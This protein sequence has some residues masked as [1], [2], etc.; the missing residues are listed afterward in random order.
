MRIPVAWLREYCDPGLGVDDLATAL[1]LSGTE[2]ERIGTVG[3]PQMDGNRS[4]FLVGEV[5]AVDEGL[6]TV[7]VVGSNSL[8]DHVIA[9]GTLTIGG[10]A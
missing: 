5:T 8:G 6:I 3:V 1:A 10:N 9:T 2:V 7:K 4:L